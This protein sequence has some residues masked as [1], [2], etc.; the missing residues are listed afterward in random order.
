M[1]PTSYQL[2][3]PAIFFNSLVQQR[4]RTPEPLLSRKRYYTASRWKMQHLF[5]D[6]LIFLK[7]SL[8]TGRLF[9]L[10][11]RKIGCVQRSGNAVNECASKRK[12]PKNGENWGFWFLGHKIEVSGKRGKRKIDDFMSNI[13]TVAGESLYKIRGQKRENGST[14]TKMPCRKYSQQN[15]DFGA[16]VKERGANRCAAGRWVTGANERK[17]GGCGEKL[18]G[19]DLRR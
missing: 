14:S 2:L 6:F 13:S 9:L 10:L 17:S 18:R 12:I 15:G 11:R 16:R 19:F 1:S 8:D 5:S 7:K 3:H 4:R